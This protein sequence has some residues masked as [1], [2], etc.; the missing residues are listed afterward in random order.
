[1]AT[2]NIFRSHVLKDDGNSGKP[3]EIATP[4]IITKAHV[5]AEARSIDVN[6]AQQDKQP[7]IEIHKDEHGILSAIDVTCS[8]GQS[9]TII[10]EYE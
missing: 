9:F 5:E 2:R 8:C 10:L 6:N 4:K 7:E 3:R 1:M